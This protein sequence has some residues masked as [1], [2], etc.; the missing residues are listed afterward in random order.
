MTAS[1][2][3]INFI[4]N[5]E[6]CVLHSYKDSA[7]V[8]TIGWGST[9]YKTG[10]RVGPGETITQQDAD[11]LLRWEV[12]NKQASV[13]AFVSNLKLNQNQYDALV[14][15]AYNVGIGALQ[16]STLLKVIKKNPADPYIRDFFAMWNKITVG[17]KKVVSKGLTLRRKREADLY[18]TPIKTF[19]KDYRDGNNK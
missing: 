18:F 5:E 1:E 8:W 19:M 11:D 9:M 12:G 13:S 2:N 6:S 14:S 10:K 7:G 4:K 16:G 15:F 17:G 3:G